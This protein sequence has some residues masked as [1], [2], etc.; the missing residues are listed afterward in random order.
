M[1][2]A[3]QQTTIASQRRRSSPADS[4]ATATSEGYPGLDAASSRYPRGMD[5]AC[6]GAIIRDGDGRLVVIR[7][8]RPPGMG[9]WSVPGGRVEPGE[10]LIAAVRREV[11]EETGLEVEVG[12]PA[13]NVVL[14]A[15]SLA[16]KYV[17]T[18][19][20]AVVATGSTTT[21]QAGDDATEAR[22]VSQHE[23]EALDLT[24]GLSQTLER[25]GVWRRNERQ[26][27]TTPP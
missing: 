24:A 9:L 3:P 13:G 25:W 19:F 17:V 1:N 16:D 27:P 22:W 8:G 23:F 21:T 20:W 11:R 7:R 15:L 2:S 26:A 10:S 5:I 18:D 12:E 4:S 6:V 14:A